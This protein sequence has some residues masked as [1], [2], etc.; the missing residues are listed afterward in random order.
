MKLSQ[1]KIR[2]MAH[3]TVDCFAYLNRACQEVVPFFEGV[4]GGRNTETKQKS[5][6]DH[7]RESFQKHSRQIR[8]ATSE[9]KH[10]I[11]VIQVQSPSVMDMDQG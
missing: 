11:I 1:N 7:P 2:L 8:I 4:E 9:I 5:L 6:K 3:S 10:A